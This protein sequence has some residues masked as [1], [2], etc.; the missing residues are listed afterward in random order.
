MPEESEEIRGALKGSE[1]SGL[2]VQEVVPVF[3]RA[4]SAYFQGAGQHGRNP[5][6][7]AALDML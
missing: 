6:L 3:L 2:G 1:G 7:E 5:C 4:F